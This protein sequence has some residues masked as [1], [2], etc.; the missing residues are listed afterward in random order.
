MVHGQSQTKP[1][2]ADSDEDIVNDVDD[3]VNVIDCSDLELELE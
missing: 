2:A 1:S 3:N